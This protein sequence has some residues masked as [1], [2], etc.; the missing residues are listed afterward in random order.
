MAT[1]TIDL[2]EGEYYHVYNRGTEKRTI[3]MDTADYVRFMELL[4][5]S[6]STKPVNVRNIR[7]DHNSIYDFDSGDKLVAIG[8]YCLMPNHFHILAT[9]IIEG[10]L[11]TFM[12]KL[13]TGYSM[14]FNKRYK[15]TG[16]LFQGSFRSKHANGDEYLKYLFS[17]IHLNPIKLI[18]SDWKEIGVK[19]IDTTFQYVSSYRYS[20]LMSYL[21]LGGKYKVIINPEKFP[22][23]FPSSENIK[24][25]LFEWLKYNP[26][27]FNL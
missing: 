25:E 20:S 14:Y 5:L 15:R 24:H 22:E 13:S 18:Q 9:P 1:R 16:S 4:F 10:G 17:Y 26:D 19:N 12:N 2:V 8:A 11:S 27:D 21:N 3:F 23:Y 7:R 6:N